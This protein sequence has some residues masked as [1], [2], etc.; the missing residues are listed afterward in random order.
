KTPLDID[1]FKGVSSKRLFAPEMQGMRRLFPPNV[2]IGPFKWMFDRYGV[3]A[4]L[5]NDSIAL[6][7]V[8]EIGP[9][10]KTIGRVIKGSGEAEKVKLRLPENRAVPGSR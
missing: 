3:I 6:G 5:I 2:H 4:V 1:Q 10:D 7:A 8:G 9:D